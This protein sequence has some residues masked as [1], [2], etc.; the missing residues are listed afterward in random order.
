[1]LHELHDLVKQPH[2][3]WVDAVGGHLNVCVCVVCVCVVCACV[4]CLWCV[5]KECAWC[6]CV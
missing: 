1:M 6:V 4:V 3:H 5:C 2:H